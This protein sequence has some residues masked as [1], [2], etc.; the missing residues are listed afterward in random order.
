MDNDR[1]IPA[2][3]GFTP[4]TTESCTK[5]TGS[6]PLARGL[7]RATGPVVGLDRIIPARAGF[8]LA[9]VGRLSYGEDHPRSRGVYTEMT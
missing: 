8:T 3:A 4:M 5:R 6:S 9:G 1:I 2:R 7:R